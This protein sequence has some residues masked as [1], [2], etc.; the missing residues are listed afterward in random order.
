M[1]QLDLN[2]VENLYSAFRLGS[3]LSF[4]LSP[5][6]LECLML[7]RVERMTLSFR[8]EKADFISGL[9]RL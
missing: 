8:K 6:L 5:P 7:S 4:Q 3:I 9:L 2:K 1:N